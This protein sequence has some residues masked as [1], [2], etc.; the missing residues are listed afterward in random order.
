MTKYIYLKRNILTILNWN[1]VEKFCLFQTVN[2]DIRK[3]TYTHKFVF[4]SLLGPF[5]DF[6]SF[7]VIFTAQLWPPTRDEYQI[8][9]FYDYWPN[10][11]WT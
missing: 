5:M 10:S 2:I 11:V 6:H 4:L 9:H 7:P 8:Q 3:Y 1:T